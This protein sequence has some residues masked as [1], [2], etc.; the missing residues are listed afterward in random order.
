MKL[1]EILQENEDKRLVLPDFQ[2]DLEWQTEKQ[3]KLLASFL[4]DL[5]VG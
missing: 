1:K 2:R 4:V 3:K 5:P